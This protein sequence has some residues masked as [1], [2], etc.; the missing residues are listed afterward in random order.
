MMADVQ[1]GD[2]HQGNILAES[3]ENVLGQ[4]LA[5]FYFQRKNCACVSITLNLA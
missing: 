1:I 3:L 5:G 4:G 2:V